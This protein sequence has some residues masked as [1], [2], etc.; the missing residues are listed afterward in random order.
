MVEE[1]GELGI[2]EPLSEERSKERKTSPEAKKS[3]FSRHSED[4]KKE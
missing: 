1:E 2:V 4:S 3:F